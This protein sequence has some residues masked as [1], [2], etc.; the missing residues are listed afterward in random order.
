MDTTAI[1]TEAVST[2]HANQ[3]PVEAAG[4]L[5]LVAKGSTVVEI[6]CD[7][8]GML[9]AY[10]AAGA[11]RVIGVDLQAA[12]WGSGMACDPHGATLIQGDSH[13]S[14]TYQSLLD[15][16]A[17]SNVD[18][19]L[20]DADHTEAGARLDYEMY[21]SLVRT[22]HVAFH[23]I[24]PHADFPTMGVDR[25]WWDVCRDHPTRTFEIVNRHRPAYTG[26]GIGVLAC[27]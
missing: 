3:D 11:G 22:G 23:D 21:A 7:R 27:G 2:W 8:G 16:L 6:G 12:G 9:W 5:H 26:M 13:R 24:C 10:R 15:V 19:L 1:A 20:I 17:G 25:V 4:L 18:L 14:E